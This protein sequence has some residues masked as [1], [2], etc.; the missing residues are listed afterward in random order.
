[1]I[2]ITG[3]YIRYFQNN[4]KLIDGIVC[5]TNNV[6]NK[7][8]E[9]VMGAGIAKIFRD[10]IVPGI[11]MFWGSRLLKLRANYPNKYNPVLIQYMYED[12]TESNYPI[13]VF[14]F[15]TKYHWKDQSD[16]KL[17]E[18]SAIKLVELC[19]IMGLEKI[20]MTR[21]GCGNGGL[22]WEDVKPAISFLDDRFVVIN[23]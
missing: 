15:P 4:H 16:M 6:V 10:K 11:Q 7:N 12:V 21:P 2:E 19:N 13:H 22:K 1:M 3:D 9:L 20:L 17:I 18:K 23:K 5:T 14:S 8:K